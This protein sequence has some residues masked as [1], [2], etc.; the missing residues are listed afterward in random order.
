[1]SRLSQFFD[2]LILENPRA[3][4]MVVVLVALLGIIK[5]PELKLDA[6]ADSLVLEGDKALEVY[7]ETA[8]RFGTREFLVVTYRP[9]ADL[10]SDYALSRLDALANEL[11]AVPRVESVL[12]LIDAPLLYSPPVPFTALNEEPRTLRDPE[13]DREAAREELRGSPIYHNLIL[14]EDGQ[15]TAIQVNLARDLRYESLLERREALRAAHRNGELDS[16]GKKQLAQVEREF[17]EYSAEVLERQ[18]DYVHQVREILDRYRS[19][20][21][22]FLGGVPMIAVDMI[23]FVRN[24]LLVFGGAILLFIVVLLVFI[25]RE[26]RFV[27]IPLATCA[28]SCLLMLSLLA[29]LDWRM[30][31]ISS[32]FIALLLILTLAVTVHLV[33]RY[34]ELHAREADLTQRELVLKTVELMAGPCLYTALTTIVA[35]ASLVVSG[36]KPVIDFGW[37]MTIGVALALVLSFLLLPSLLMLLEKK[38]AIRLDEA[39]EKPFTLVFA[40]ITDRF[41][42]LILALSAALAVLSGFGI[43]RLQVENRFIDYFD[44]DT[45][46]YQGMVVIDRELGGTIPLWIVLDAEKLPGQVKASDD[47]FDEFDFD[48]EHGTSE[49][50]PFADEFTDQTNPGADGSP[51]STWFTTYRLDR[52]DTIQRHLSE[53]DETGK[54]LSL[55]TLYEVGRDLIG[56]HVDDIQLA[57]AYKSLSD[58]VR[59]V[60]VDPYLDPKNEQTLI[61]IRVKET[62][63]SLRRNAFLHEVERYL[64]HDVGLKPD[65]FRLTGMLVLYNNM[66]QS[67]FKSQIMT[68]GAVFVAI[69]TMFMILFRSFS[70]ALITLAPNILAA[71]VVLGGMGLVGIPLDIMT[72]TVAAIVVG[73]GVDDSIH[74]VH[75]FVREFQQD[76]N[77]RATMFRCHASIGRAMYY[78]SVIIV[79]GVSILVLSN[80]RPS[81]Y[82]GLLTAVAMIAALLGSLL[83]LPRLLLALRPLG[84]EGNKEDPE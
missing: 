30:T 66:L 9:D 8:K 2:R 73:I 13:V 63:K 6:S 80:F 21:T 68:L 55:A 53:M 41:G 16:A 7:R 23:D 20:A 70:L 44:S 34:R 61:S 74:Y 17:K 48:E 25:F 79:A 24:D 18:H 1:M 31:V 64:E 56:G 50:D 76:R 60:L 59:R 82:F 32:N 84:P 10:M 77:Y 36:I 11:R 5:L 51:V 72:I 14:G 40:R 81:I 83:L 12:T 78:T 57:V 67:L 37:M 38:S 19:D 33:V 39:P 62:S 69:L 52:L 15:T 3:T 75:R 43:S 29:W 27:L 47:A 46:I 4:L 45:E 71:A 28:S 54:V 58:E 22:I 35:F 49:E 65:H 26:P 42:G